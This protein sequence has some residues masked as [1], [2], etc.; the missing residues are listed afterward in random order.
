VA[1]ANQYVTLT[2]SLAALDKAY[3]L[4]EADTLAAMASGLA[5][6]SPSPWAA[7]YAAQM[8]SYESWSSGAAAAQESERV[9]SA[10]EQRNGEIGLADSERDASISSANADY[11]QAFATAG[12]AQAAGLGQAAAVAALGSSN[13][14][15]L[16]HLSAFTISSTEYAIAAASAS[17]YYVN[18][19][20]SSYWGWGYY[21]WGWNDYDSSVAASS[22]ATLDW[23]A[24][25]GPATRAKTPPFTSPLS[26]SSPPASGT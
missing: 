16:P 17:D 7:Q 20:Q 14:A 25:V 8:N 6:S 5:T 10:S 2:T 26:S 12:A 18:I 15:V 4:L 1:D 24:S 22:A 3:W 13:R 11:A 21:G 23:M 9:S 19:N